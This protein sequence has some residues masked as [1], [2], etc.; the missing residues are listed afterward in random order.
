MPWPARE[1]SG[2]HTFPARDEVWYR[3]S[4]LVAVVGWVQHMIGISEMG[5]STVPEDVLVTYSLGSCIG[6]TLYD[7]VLPVGEMVHCM[8]PESTVDPLKAERNPEMFV[9]S[10][11]AL[12]IQ[13]VLELGAQRRRL[14]AKVAG[15]ST[16]LDDHG[17]FNV[18]ER[19]YIMLRK[20]LWKNDI[21]IWA[22]ETG[23]NIAR[24]LYLYMETGRT[25]IKSQGRERELV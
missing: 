14:M 1:F 3:E 22:E 2:R 8:L 9:D 16:L 17:A 13:R 20:I 25:T 21:R 5:I 18:G 7:P 4:V 15:A 6:L 12:L 19:N 24:T 23:G 10:G 11:V